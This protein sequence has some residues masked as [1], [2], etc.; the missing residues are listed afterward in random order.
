MAPLKINIDEKIDF[1]TFV[2]GIAKDSMDML[3]HQKYSYQYLLEEL[4]KKD[5]NIPNL[6]NILLSYQITNAH[7][8]ADD[9]QY[10][11][12]WT[13]NG[14]CAENIDIQI[15]DLNDTG[16]LNISYDYKSSIYHT[17][18]IEKIHERILNII[19]QVIKKEEINI[20]EIQVVTEEERKEL[21]E[22]FNNTE[23]EYNKNIPIIKYFEE[24]VEKTPNIAAIVFENE[25]MNYKELNEKANSLAYELRKNGV[26][27]N[28]IVGILQERSFEMLIAILAVL[29]SGG[30]YIPIAP[31][32]PNERIEYMLKDSN[33]SILL[34]SEGHIINTDK[35]II[36]IS[37]KNSK[38]YNEH[39]ENLEN[40]SKPED[41]SYLIYTSG[42]TGTP[43]GV[44][45][46]Q[47]NLSNFYNSMKHKIEY[48]ND[49]KQHKILSITTVSFDIFE[50][51]TLM[52]L[53][54]GL[55][56]YLT[57][58]NEQKITSEIEKIIKQNNIEIMQTT[59]SVMKFHLENIRNK[60]DIKSLKYI[61]LAGEPLPKTLVEKIKK[62]IPEVQVLNGYG[63]SETTIFSTI[64]NVTKQKEI[65]I[66]R[67]INNTQI[68]IL[69]KNKKLM[70]Q[71]TIG[72]LYISGDGV[73]KG[74]INKEKQTRENFIKN[75]FD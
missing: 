41:L 32:Y 2:K 67:P 26:T 5:N 48:L 25:K 64:A 31:D 12:E 62:I 28:T 58:E 57:N 43:K 39:K 30:S 35:K 55:T 33:A 10:E 75:P 53:T 27:N 71:G 47:Q 23:L 19:N 7:Q 17:K 4:R 72:E 22:E 18:D 40:I 44:M 74:Y 38:I 42:S 21:L 65:T 11:T 1:K 16:K 56:V 8:N 20:S 36:D 51:E 46:K 6:Y 54:R 69:N 13:F 15:F 66:G 59:P 60:N 73:G 45:L 63:P 14:C 37:L 24:Q 61:I 68:Y 9:V 49:D 52:S 50:F 29:K 3:K 34:T 70:P